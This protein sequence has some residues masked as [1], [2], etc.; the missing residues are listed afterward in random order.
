MRWVPVMTTRSVSQN[1]MLLLLSA[2]SVFA[3][4]RSIPLDKTDRLDLRGV[5]AEI[6]EYRGRTALKLTEE[7]QSN[8]PG[9]AV[10]KNVTMREGTI[11]V[12][13]SGRPAA[14]AMEGA[15]GFVGVAFRV[16][17]DAKRFEYIYLRPTNGRAEDQVRR[18][19]SV[20][21]SS[22]PDYPWHRIRQEEPGKYETYV[23]L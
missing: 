3:A 22:H 2:S 11:E 13:V 20:Q 1:F 18:N 9:L 4:Q 16:S 23:D 10:L 14:G 17:P 12:D 19:H 6:V 7:P 8:D 15:R 21:Y 5:K